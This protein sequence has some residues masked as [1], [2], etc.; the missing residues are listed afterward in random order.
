MPGCRGSSWRPTGCRSTPADD[1]HVT[2]E[3]EAGA[4][5]GD[6]DRA[7]LPPPAPSGLGLGVGEGDFDVEK[8]PVLT[9]AVLPTA[10]AVM[11]LIVAETSV[12]L[13]V[14][15]LVAAEKAVCEV[16]SARAVFLELRLV[17][18]RRWGARP[19]ALT[20]RTL[21]LA[22]C[23]PKSVAS[24]RMPVPRLGLEP[25]MLVKLLMAA[26]MLFGLVEELK[27]SWRMPAEPP[28]SMVNWLPPVLV[29]ELPK[30]E[31]AALLSR[32][33]DEHVNVHAAAEL[34]ALIL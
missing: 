12:P 5:A 20:T 11:P 33:G 8:S 31:Q 32:G 30:E 22:L 14:M 15:V 34:A 26:A 24:R 10:V 6:R 13:S 2:A 7:W 28:T 27:V 1:V 4:A 17:R 23:E 19:P 3:L 21:E 29:V 16:V 25:V 9:R 18:Y